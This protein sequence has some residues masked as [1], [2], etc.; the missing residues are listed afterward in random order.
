[1]KVLLFARDP[2]GANAVVPLAPILAERGHQVLLYG[3]DAALK[4]YLVYG[5]AGLDLAVAAPEMSVDSYTG[6]L[7]R[8]APDFL[9]TATGSDDFAEKLLWQAAERLEIPSFAILDHWFNY[10]IRFSPY[11]LVEQELYE[12]DKRHPFLP[13]RIL[14]M[15]DEVRAAMIQEGFAP[16]RIL[17]AGQPHFDSLRQQAERFS[18]EEVKQ[19]R[20]QLGIAETVFLLCFISENI[21]ELDKGD[22]LGQYYWGYTERSIFCELMDAL[23]AAT[24]ASGRKVH[25]VVKPHPNETFDAYSDLIAAKAG[26]MVS[27]NIDTAVHPVKLCKAVD[28]VCGMSSMVLVEAVIMGL[29]VLSIQIGLRHE[30]PFILDKKGVVRSILQR[31]ELQRT[32][33]ACLNGSSLDATPFNVPTGAAERIIKWMEEWR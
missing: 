17:V 27:A 25:V 28:L 26:G 8:L 1:M 14:V 7:K 2:G 3:K 19:Y 24:A 5:Q 29:P 4:Q 31:R 30:N 18:A 10:G 21:T 12:Q 23:Q 13:S 9:I 33:T 16:E 6:F 32:L 11:K 15:D 22:D 20:A